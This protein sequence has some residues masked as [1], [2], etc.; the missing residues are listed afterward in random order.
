[1]P[2]ISVIIPTKNR[3]DLLVQT[4]A[5]VVAQTEGDWEAI[6]VD[7]GSTDGTLGYLRA[8]A[9]EDERIRVL[10][11]RGPIGGAC[12][13]R[14]Q[15]LAAARSDTIVFL[16][17]DD[18]LEPFALEDRLA[19][20][21]QKPEID[22][23]VNQARC[24]RQQPGDMNT[25][26][27]VDPPGLTPDADIDRFLR[28]DIPWQTTGATWRRRA[29]ARLSSPRCHG[30]RGG[31]LGPWDEHA[32]SGQ[33]LEMHVRALLLGLRYERTMPYD[34]H[35]RAGSAGRSSV[36][37]ASIQAAHWAYRSVIAERFRK[38]MLQ[39]GRLTPLRRNL[40]AGAFW[41]SADNV[42]QR[43]GVRQA[44]RIWDRARVLGLTSTRRWLEGS[45]YLIGFGQRQLREPAKRWIGRSWPP[46]LLL[47]PSPTH[48]RAPVPPE[49]ERQLIERRNR[50]KSVAAG[51][52]GVRL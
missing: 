42:R 46:E 2:R 10:R 12:V 34:F 41:N 43:A 48:T 23:L 40:L 35:W 4:L 44:T 20:L 6:V 49:Q 39:T 28:R 47:T 25:L 30:P 1:M 17:S 50:A 13:A 29:L 5:S 22:F 21:A 32:P 9:R 51:L 24:F 14:N 37:L 16:D 26:W 18:I 19:A 8:A 33:D 31:G 45:A 15:G 7:D 52:R 3:R 11:R 27:N 38:L 36:G